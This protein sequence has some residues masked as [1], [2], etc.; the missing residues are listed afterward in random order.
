MFSIYLGDLFPD[1]DAELYVT[2][3]ELEACCKDLIDNAIQITEDTLEQTNLK[4]S[5]ITEILLVGGSSR[6]PVLTKRLSELFP[7]KKLN[8]SVNV[9]EAVAHGAAVRAA[10]LCEFTKV[11]FCL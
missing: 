1:L 3:D 6:I 4:P 9:D 7:G 10:Q 2:R 5:D 11:I 8:N